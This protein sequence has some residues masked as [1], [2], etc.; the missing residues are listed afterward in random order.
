MEN[1]VLNHVTR[2]KVTYLVAAAIMMVGGFTL[3]SS[4]SLPNFYDSNNRV[5]SGNVGDLANAGSPVTFMEDALASTV[6][7]TGEEMEVQWQNNTDSPVTLYLVSAT[8]KAQRPIKLQSNITNDG[9]VTSY[10][11]TVP[12]SIAT[13]NY[14]FGVSADNKLVRTDSYFTVV[15]TDGAQSEAR[16]ALQSQL[17]TVQA[18]LEAAKTQW[19]AVTTQMERKNAS[20]S[21]LT[22]ELDSTNAQLNQAIS[23]YYN[24]K[25]TASTSSP[26]FR[27]ALT[28]VYNTN[29]ALARINL[30]LKQAKAEMVSLEAEAKSLEA[31]VAMQD[32]TV[33]ALE[34][35]LNQLNGEIKLN[36]SLT[37]F[38]DKNSLSQMES[39]PTSSA[40]V[41]TASNTAQVSLNEVTAQISEKE[42]QIAELQEELE[43][44]QT[45]FEEGDFDLSSAQKD[46]EAALNRVEEL[47]VTLNEAQDAVNALNKRIAE[48]KDVSSKANLEAE[49]DTAQAE[50]DTAQAE[51]SAAQEEAQA[52][53]QRLSSGLRVPTAKDDA[54]YQE[55]QA[56]LKTAQAELSEL[57]TQLTQLGG[58]VTVTASSSDRISSGEDEVTRN[59]ENNDDDLS[60]QSEEAESNVTRTEEGTVSANLEPAS[61]AT[62]VTTGLTSPA[63]FEGGGV[64]TS[65]SAKTTEESTAQ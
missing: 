61:E 40:S 59:E 20:L 63:R 33:T 3:T 12:S 21:Q 48:S 15:K 26:E 29:N 18:S 8:N 38:E 2:H 54:A 6:L 31:N 16:S 10:E 55:I 11:W 4:R 14:V 39:R 64:S 42:A 41:S 35:K 47:K 53:Q 62:E 46:T 28:D 60:D 44:A 49:L 9:R 51:L 52:A 32:V 19:E 37:A 17:N 23:A 30:S 65:L 1:K 25:K 45:A 50:L 27:A 24:A 13:G 5:Y 43:T 22:Q 36:S 34:D 57:K 56:E 58:E 7:T